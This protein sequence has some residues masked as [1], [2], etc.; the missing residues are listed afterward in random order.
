MKKFLALA[1]VL[2]MTTMAGA[3]L[4][5]S[6]YNNPAGGENWVPTDPQDSQI[7]IRPTDT[8]SLSIWTDSEI[9]PGGNATW[10]LTV[11][12]TVGD[13]SGGQAVLT[14]PYVLIVQG[15]IADNETIIPPTGEDGVWGTLL[16]G[17]FVGGSSIPAGTV[18]FEGFAFQCMDSGD[19]VINLFDN[20]VED[21]LMSNPIDSIVIHQ[22]PEPLTLTLM[23]LGG[24]GI[25]R[26][27]RA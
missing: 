25:L 10:A 20:V 26:R 7:S 11:D 6:V 16:N 9:T 24:L 21:V 8:L 5:I 18:L 14:N 12:T 27:R 1:L 17:D 15:A 23:G 13:I 19:A 22:I 2:G 3:A 4:Q